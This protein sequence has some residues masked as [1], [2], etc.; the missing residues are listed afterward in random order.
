MSGTRPGSWPAPVAGPCNTTAR[1]QEPGGRILAYPEV[2][3]ERLRRR[4]PPIQLG[5][6]LICLPVSCAPTARGQQDSRHC[7]A[8]GDSLNRRQ[9]G[10]SDCC[11]ARPS[12]ITVQ[13]LTP[14]LPYRT[15]SIRAY[16]DTPSRFNASLPDDCTLGLFGATARARRKSAMGSSRRPR[17]SK[18]LP[19][20]SSAGALL[21]FNSSGFSTSG[22]P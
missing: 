22:N 2:T 17:T 18:I 9:R 14:K 7:M 13:P 21:G 16:G 3:I 12:T 5:P 4:R 10:S 11:M 15:H 19:L 1:S 6:T 8:S 20:V